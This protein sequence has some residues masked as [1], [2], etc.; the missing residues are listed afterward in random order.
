M[1]IPPW[2]WFSILPLFAGYD[3]RMQEIRDSVGSASRQ[4]GEADKVMQMIAS[5]DSLD[6]TAVISDLASLPS[7]RPW[8]FGS[9]PKLEPGGSNRPEVD[10]LDEWV[11]VAVKS[12]GSRLQEVD[13]ATNER[14]S[15][16]GSLV[17]AVE[18]VRLQRR[19]AI[20]T[21]LL[22]AVGIVTLGALLWPSSE[23]ARELLSKAQD[24][25]AKLLAFVS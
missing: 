17:G 13:R 25:W 23:T 12:W 7:G 8:I 15:Q 6:M 2:Y 3:Y 4:P 16:F 21:W 20:L 24:L 1:H 19:I 22:L 9:I 10:S 18:N 5:S 14:L 11:R